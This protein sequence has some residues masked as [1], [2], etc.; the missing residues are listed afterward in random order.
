MS[1]AG[2][3][4]WCAEMV[5]VVLIYCCIL[6]VVWVLEVGLGTKRLQLVS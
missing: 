6:H 2:D 5:L 4:A 1:E 3:L